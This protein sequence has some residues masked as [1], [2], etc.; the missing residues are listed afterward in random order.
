[1]AG[2]EQEIRALIDLWI[3]A[4][5]ENDLETV[6]GL[7]DEDAVFLLPGRGPMRRDEFEKISRA[8]AGRIKFEGKPDIQEIHV[9][10]DWAY[11][12]NH[13]SVTI[14]PLPDGAPMYRAGDILTI[15]RKGTDGKWR[16]FRDANL[17]SAAG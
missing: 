7:M 6:L 4:S 16:L 15:F 10:G 2:D 13:L 1:M 17:L 8:G 3:K 12:W 5:R 9:N 11:C 14:T